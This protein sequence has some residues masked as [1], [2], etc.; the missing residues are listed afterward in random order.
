MAGFSPF[1]HLVDL[2]EFLR[3]EHA[4]IHRYLDDSG[5]SAADDP[6][7]PAHISEY[8][9]ELFTTWAT[10][11]TPT[12]IRQS[13]LNKLCTTR[14]NRRVDPDDSSHAWVLRGVIHSVGHFPEQDAAT[15]FVQQ[16]T[17]EHVIA[18]A[19]HGAL[20]PHLKARLWEGRRISFANVF[21]SNQHMIPTQT[22]VIDLERR[23]TDVDFVV[24]STASFSLRNL[25]AAQ[26]PGALLLRIQGK[27]ETGIVFSDGNQLVEL[28][29]ERGQLDLRRLLCFGDVIVLYRPWVRQIEAE[30][31]SLVYGP[32]T[33]IFRVPAVTR[34][35]KGSSQISQHRHSFGQDGLAFRNMAN[36]R[37]VQ[38]TVDR[39]TH[40]ADSS[41]L[42]LCDSH[43]HSV[44]VSVG[45]A[46]CNYE[47]QKALTLVRRSHYLWIF[48]L[49][50]SVS[51]VL[52]FTNETTMFNPG[53]MYSI[54]ASDIVTPQDLSFLGRF[55][56]FVARAIVI[57]LDCQVITV[58]EVCKGALSR[59]GTCSVCAQRGCTGRKEL[60]LFIAIDDGS[61]DAVEVAA[62]GSKLPFWGVTVARWETVD[63]EDRKALIRQLVGREFVFVL[64]QCDETEFGETR[65][66]VTWRVDQCTSPVGDVEREV[67]RIRQWHEEQNA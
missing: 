9:L 30:V 44:T 33:V 63:V 40:I 21:F 45:W 37:S 31:P 42:T 23:K 25:S 55:E 24:G 4:A 61:C 19:A 32:S 6:D 60:V 15:L 62:L 48:G 58:Q 65:N 50:E 18:V 27:T 49:N 3:L 54:I 5:D 51:K 12:M 28:H 1:R 22:V 43:G 47:M 57:G 20:L 29:L 11:I 36:C 10:G 7:L 59:N 2:Q 34:G 64:S 53:L 26:P 56:S 14:T 17:S 52:N 41:E 16:E 38:G 39:I 67:S 13:V 8:V 35:L 46:D 66:P